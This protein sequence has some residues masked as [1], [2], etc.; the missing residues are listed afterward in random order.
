VSYPASPPSTTINPCPAARIPSSLSL[1]FLLLFTLLFRRISPPPDPPIA[2]HL[3]FGHSALEARATIERKLSC[4]SPS[5]YPR[6]LGQRHNKPLLVAREPSSTGKCFDTFSSLRLIG[7]ERVH[8]SLRCLVHRQYWHRMQATQMP[9]ADIF[10]RR[11][12]AFRS[13][14]WLGMVRAPHPP[15]FFLSQRD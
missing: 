7:E 13:M 3:R 11:Y 1:C 9:P 14:R 2:L 10:S 4:S 12:R 15:R 8:P 5:S 6:A